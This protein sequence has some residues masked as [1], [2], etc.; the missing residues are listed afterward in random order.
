MRDDKIF[1]AVKA[2]YNALDDKLA[3]DIRVLEIGE[4]SPMADYFVIAS[5]NNPNQL[6]AMAD[7]VDEA[8]YKAGFKLNH[9]EGMQ[10]KSWL[11]LD[12]GEIV[13]HLFSKEDRDFYNLERIWGDA[14]EVPAEELIEK[15]EA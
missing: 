10:T 14:K 15:K 4:I 6:K 12:F 5:G 8:L 9:S 3:V 2:A 13:V 1:S 7:S 11:L